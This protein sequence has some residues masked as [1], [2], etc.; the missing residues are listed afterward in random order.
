MWYM[1]SQPDV[2][3]VPILLIEIS[4]LYIAFESVAGTVLLLINRLFHPSIEGDALL[5][6]IMNLVFSC[7]LSFFSFF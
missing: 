3:V 7:L 2:V 6:I 5:I 1:Q 4:A